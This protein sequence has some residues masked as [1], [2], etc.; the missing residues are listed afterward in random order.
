MMEEVVWSCK[1]GSI[2]EVAGVA[3]WGLRRQPLGSQ[4]RVARSQQS[5][6]PATQPTFDPERG[7]GPESIKMMGVVLTINLTV[8]R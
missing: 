1:E 8:V 5:L 6:L 2:W 3:R 4:L 7:V